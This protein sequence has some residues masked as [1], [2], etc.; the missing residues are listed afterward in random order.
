[1]HAIGRK[2]GHRFR[3]LTVLVACLAAASPGCSGCLGRQQK[4]STPDAD[5]VADGGVAEFLA[6]Q[7]SLP[8]ELQ[9]TLLIGEADDANRYS[10]TVA[11]FARAPSGQPRYRGCAGVLLSADLVLTAAHCVCRPHMDSQGG[12]GEILRIA[13]LACAA[14]ASVRTY[15]FE[16]LPG[17]KGMESWSVE[18]EGAVQPHP[19]FEL[20]MD[21]QGAVMAS[22]ADLAVVRLDAHV[23][24]N[25]PP[26][27]L[28]EQAAQP[29]ELMTV[30]GYGYIEAIGGMDGNRR[31]SRERVKKLLDPSGERVEF[32][33][34]DLRA[35]KGDTGGPC[36]RETEHGP[37]LLGISSRGLGK[38]PTFTSI[39]PY[40]NWLNEQVLL[41]ST[42]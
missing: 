6:R 26:V 9:S 16:P 1:M 15:T 39:S 33:A 29:G 18:Y 5:E 35:Y 21:A 32:G 31:F 36:L 13:A 19:G 24:S 40:R 27:R 17:T 7:A 34:R 38:E 8:P 37:E 23:Q 12:S 30:V 25:I 2:Q 20:L 10:S 11:V 4:E 42:P 41:R 14:T 3:T 22:R 28:A